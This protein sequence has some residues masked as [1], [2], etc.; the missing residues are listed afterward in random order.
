M[1]LKKTRILAV[2]ALAVTSLLASQIWAA[3]TAKPTW[4]G[5]DVG[6]VGLAGSFAEKDGVFTVNG[7][8]GGIYIA[9]DSFH[10]VH[11]PLEGDGG[12]T[13]R[14]VG[15]KNSV[16]NTTLGLMAR[17]TLEY[18]SKHV[19]LFLRP[20]RGYLAACQARTGEDIETVQTV[21]KAEGVKLPCWLRMTRQRDK[22]E[23]FL[24]QDGK[25]WKPFGEVTNTLSRYVHLG[26]I[27]CSHRTN[28]L[29]EGV[30]DHVTVSGV[31]PPAERFRAEVVKTLNRLWGEK[32]RDPR[33]A[34]FDALATK[35]RDERAGLAFPKR[36]KLISANVHPMPPP[37]EFKAR[38]KEY[39]QRPY[40]GVLFT[41]KGGQ[42]PFQR[43]PWD[44]A[45]FVEDYEALADLQSRVLTDNFIVVH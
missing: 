40:D 13:V 1:T 25:E 4:I 35:R 6:K 36:K 11:V 5:V 45:R 29:T 12:I 7:A 15:M 19:Y 26:M 37:A 16:A 31:M 18:D 44:E 2:C 32:P 9:G 30:F 20:N 10:Y 8:G 33:L 3:D 43:R 41:L 24:S 17:E 38:L 39:E 28:L 27:V 21:A 34:A 42:R 22:F 23:T 14:V